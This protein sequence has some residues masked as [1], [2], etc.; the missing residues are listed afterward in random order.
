MLWTLLVID[1]L[2]SADVVAT[3]RG[4][5]SSLGAVEPHGRSESAVA[6]PLYPRPHTA[7]AD[8]DSHW[9]PGFHIPGT[10]FIT[11]SLI[12]HDGYVV[13]AGHFLGAGSSLAR[14]LA[15]W[16]GERWF[17]WPIEP[18]AAVWALEHYGGQLVAGGSFTQF[19]DVVASHVAAGTVS[20][21]S[22]LALV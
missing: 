19:G 15:R 22:P 4:I 11:E 13:A 5:Y 20:R 21:G 12:E 9:Q 16:D 10:S 6:Q 1:A 18:E 7:T 8:D 17:R 14:F 3:H 2:V